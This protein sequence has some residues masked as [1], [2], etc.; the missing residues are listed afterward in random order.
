MTFLPPSSRHRMMHKTSLGT[1]DDNVISGKDLLDTY[2]KIL[3]SIKN[4]T[5]AVAKGI[6]KSY[7]TLRDLYEGWAALGSVKEKQLMLV[8]I[9]VSRTL[10]LTS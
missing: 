10:A 2:I 4:V 7:P 6:A 9:G 5:E 3:A 8:G 1:V